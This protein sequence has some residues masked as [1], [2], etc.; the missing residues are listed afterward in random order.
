M[1]VVILEIGDLNRH[2]PGLDPLVAED[3]IK[4]AMA[5][6]AIKAPC[7]LDPALPDQYADAAKDIIRDV[8]LRR[9]QAGSGAVKTSTAGPYSQTIDTRTPWR[10]TFQAEDVS[11]LQDLCRRYAGGV[12]SGAL[13]GYSAPESPLCDPGYL[14]AVGLK[15]IRRLDD[16]S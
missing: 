10:K 8:V 16:L 3:L 2:V 4:G 7:I 12:S 14:T 11:G 5:H 13:P 6:A 1:P 9:I 15:K